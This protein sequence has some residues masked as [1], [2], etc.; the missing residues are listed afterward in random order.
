ML[1]E[2]GVLWLCVRW[3]GWVSGWVSSS[4]ASAGGTD[5]A[6]GENC[7]LLQEAAESSSDCATADSA[8]SVGD[9]FSAF[10]PAEQVTLFAAALVECE[11][12]RSTE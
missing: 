12:D 4:E 8:G 5:A 1:T 6:A 3:K 10:A 2:V 7:E 11:G 9:L